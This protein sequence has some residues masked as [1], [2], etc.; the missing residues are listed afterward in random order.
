MKYLVISILLK[1]WSRT[2]SF[3]PYDWYHYILFLL[4]QYFLL[5]SWHLSQLIY[6]TL[7]KGLKSLITCQEIPLNP[8][9]N[10]SFTVSQTPSIH[11]PGYSNRNGFMILMILSI[12]LFEITKVIP[13]LALTT[14]FPRIFLWIAPSIADT[15][16]RVDNVS[17]R[18]LPKEQQLASMDY[19]T[20]GTKHRKPTWL[21]YSRK[22][23][24]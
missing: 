8:P 23:C 17:E 11:A 6:F 14:H 15:D 13:F 2:K 1:G 24:I 20:Y 3:Y 4:L 18:F 22:L 21:N 5:S 7:L 19:L 9:L 12:Y 10:S 16:A